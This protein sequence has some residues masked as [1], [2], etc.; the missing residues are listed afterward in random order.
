MNEPGVRARPKR[1]MVTGVSSGFGRALSEQIVARRD[2]V[3][4]STRDPEL[5]R[6]LELQSHGQLHAIA[7]HVQSVVRVSTRWK[8]WQL[9]LCTA[10]RADDP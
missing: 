4:A 1:W 8:P 3:P 10:H 5:I 7:P 6:V 2:D 9:V